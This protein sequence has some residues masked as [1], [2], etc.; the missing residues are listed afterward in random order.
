[1]REYDIR[2]G[3]VEFLDIVELKLEEEAGRHGWLSI[4]GHIRDEEEER[5]LGQ[6]GRAH[7]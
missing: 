4:S 6:I 5:C 1:M 2:T 3:P 7:F